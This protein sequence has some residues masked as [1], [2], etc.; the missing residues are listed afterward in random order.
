M[1]G[2]DVHYHPKYFLDFINV[3]ATPLESFAARTVAFSGLAFLPPGSRPSTKQDSILHVARL[4]ALQLAA[5]SRLLKQVII[6]SWDI[7]T[8]V[9][10]TELM[11]FY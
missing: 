10:V 1:G 11:A 8:S 3:I 7:T 2:K 6:T 5:A 4:P 9:P